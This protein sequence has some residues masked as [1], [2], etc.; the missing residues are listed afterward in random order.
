M[1]ALISFTVIAYVCQYGMGSAF[2]GEKWRFVVGY[3]IPVLAMGKVVS[4]TGLSNRSIILS[5]PFVCSH[6]GGRLP[7]RQ[8]HLQGCGSFR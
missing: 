3:S 5:P 1:G 6:R 8:L 4:L 7:Q 2:G